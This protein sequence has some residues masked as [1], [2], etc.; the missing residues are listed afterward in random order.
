MLE[1][2]KKEFKFSKGVSFEMQ[3]LEYDEKEKL[4][5]VL[6]SFPTERTD[7]SD[8]K[9]ND[10]FISFL[11]KSVVMIT[12]GETSTDA[13]DTRIIKRLLGKIPSKNHVS[14]LTEMLNLGDLTELEEGN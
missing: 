11:V 1:L 5:W 12:D 10:A 14:L 13:I 3:E 2:E 9:F 6:K 8:K 7:E 4:R